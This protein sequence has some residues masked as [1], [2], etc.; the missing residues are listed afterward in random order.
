[1]KQSHVS[2]NGRG[3]TARG[4]CALLTLTVVLVP[5][6][7]ARADENGVPF[8]FSGSYFSFAAV[9]LKPGWYMPTELYYYKGSSDSSESFPRGQAANFGLSSEIAVIFFSPTWVPNEKWFGGQPSF[10]LAFG[11]GWNST[12]ADLSLSTVPPGSQTLDRSDSVT[13]G[14]D[15]Y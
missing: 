4:A 11:G 12:T 14:S 5:W 13:S 2:S 3:F 10:T 1:M 8:W 6:A 15:L 9:P 7:S